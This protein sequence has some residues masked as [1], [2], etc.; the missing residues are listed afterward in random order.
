MF[1][2]LNIDMQWA[3]SSMIFKKYQR[4]ELQGNNEY[5]QQNVLKVIERKGTYFREY[6]CQ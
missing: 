3:S 5:R 1:L 6:F 4:F 2:Y